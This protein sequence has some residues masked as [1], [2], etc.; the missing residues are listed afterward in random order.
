MLDIVL[1][2]INNVSVEGDHTARSMPRGRALR[3][4]HHGAVGHKDASLVG[5][6]GFRYRLRNSFIDLGIAGPDNW[7]G[8]GLVHFDPSS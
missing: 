6:D 3:L 4:A 7:Y 8:L 5:T 1:I 2:P